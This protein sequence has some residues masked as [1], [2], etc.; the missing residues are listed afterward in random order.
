MCDLVQ[1]WLLR[2][3]IDVAHLKK[4]IIFSKFEYQQ[5]LINNTK[6]FYLADRQAH[7][8]G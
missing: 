1:S 2:K 3:I 7:F 5:Q 6:Y 8:N 4:S